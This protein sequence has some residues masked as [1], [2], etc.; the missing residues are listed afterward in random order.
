MLDIISINDN[1]FN[2]TSDKSYEIE[3]SDFSTFNNENC[4]R[5]LNFKIN[6]FPRSNFS[7]LNN[8]FFLENKYMINFLENKYK[9]A[10]YEKK[11]IELLGIKME[12]LKHKKENNYILFIIYSSKED[13][14]EINKNYIL[15]RY[16][17]GILLFLKEINP[18]ELNIIYK[19]KFKKTEILKR[20]IKNDKY[21][22]YETDD[23]RIIET[24]IIYDTFEQ[25]KS[26]I[27]QIKLHKKISNL[28]NEERCKYCEWKNIC[29]NI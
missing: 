14:E 11:Q 15:K 3:F 12:I 16:I 7:I 24:S 29:P 27:N 25:I 9:L 23:N 22:Y 17:P 8:E 19:H 10:K 28:K 2:I 4:I 1:F 18:I 13:E 6:K 26:I 21:N 20:I 5:K